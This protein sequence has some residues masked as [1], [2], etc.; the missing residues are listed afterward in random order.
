[1]A[2][3]DV[4]TIEASYIVARRAAVLLNQ[5]CADACRLAGASGRGC[6]A[7]TGL[8]C[9]RFAQPP[10]PP[11]FELEEVVVWLD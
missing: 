9:P 5:R 11:L 1:L 7:S 6:S 2:S 10:P 3:C 8:S 4:L